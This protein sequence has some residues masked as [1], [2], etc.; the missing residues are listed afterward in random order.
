[1]KNVTQILKSSFGYYA[2]AVR[3]W[4]LE[5][6]IVVTKPFFKTFNEKEKE[7]LSRAQEIFGAQADFLDGY[8]QKESF[9][10]P[11]ED[12]TFLGNTGIV[13]QNSKIIVE[14]TMDISRMIYSKAYRKPKLLR[15]KTKKGIFTSILHLNY[16]NNFYHW[17]IDCLPRLYNIKM[18]PFT[19]EIHL[20]IHKNQPT[21]QKEILS[22]FIEKD[23]RLKPVYITNGE[24]WNLPEFWLPSFVTSGQSGFMPRENIDYVR[25]TILEGYGIQSST[26]NKA[27]YISRRLAKKRKLLNEI[28]I[29]EYLSSIGVEIIYMESLSFKAQIEAIH[30]AKLI[31]SPHGAGL[32]HVLYTISAKVIEIHPSNYVQTHYCMLSSACGHDYECFVGEK[33]DE[34]KNYNV[35]LRTFKIFINRVFRSTIISNESQKI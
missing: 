13:V 33:M 15:S 25:S 6:K 27:V 34:N 31:I 1:M 10:A 7:C 23:P 20:I 18:I 17:N 35:N 12:I 19:K 2:G 30:N 26:K 9:L 32:S 28:E 21:Y 4:Q 5:A 3:S 29:E 8:K 14:S 22:F 24:K 16:S 11:L